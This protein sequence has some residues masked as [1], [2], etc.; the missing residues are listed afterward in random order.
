MTYVV[1]DIEA[2]GPDPFANSMLSL[3]AAA[4][5][6]DLRD[7]GTFQ[8]NLAPRQGTA[9]NPRTLAWFRA[10]APAAYAAIT[11]DP[12]PPAEAVARFVAFVEAL[13]AP[14]IFVA[15]PVIFDGPW[16]DRY[17][18][19]YTG[20][21]LFDHA[22]HQ[23]PLFAR[24]GLDLPSLV[25]GVTGRAYLDSHRGRIPPEWFDAPHTHDALDDAIGYAS[26]LKHV[27]AMRPSGDS[28]VE[29]A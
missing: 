20:V 17:L 22:T 7:A 8:V 3:G 11:R 28:T 6:D 15:H 16:V 10:E 18:A 19:L 23:V 27:L 1:V 21:R 5:T 29:C 9:P 13:P 26:V 4:V 24:T 14:R 2:D 12:V 25:M